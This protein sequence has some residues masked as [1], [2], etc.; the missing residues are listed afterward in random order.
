MQEFTLQGPCQKMLS[1][2]IIIEKLYILII[3]SWQSKKPATVTKGPI[4][5]WLKVKGKYKTSLIRITGELS[6]TYKTHNK[7][8]KQHNTNHKTSHKPHKIQYNI[9]KISQQTVSVL[10]N[11]LEG[12]ETVKDTESTFARYLDGYFINRNQTTLQ[13][14]VSSVL[15]IRMGLV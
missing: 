12:H 15:C 14:K 7:T 3:L 13:T 9:L 11:F 1:I 4:S 2:T 10:H 8:D 5:W 6:K